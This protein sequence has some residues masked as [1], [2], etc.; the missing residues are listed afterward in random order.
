LIKE[1][2]EKL[3]AA[4]QYIYVDFLGPMCCLVETR[5][6]CGVQEYLAVTCSLDFSIF[7]SLTV[8]P[9]GRSHGFRHAVLCIGTLKF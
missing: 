3:I 9:C 5:L 8:G 4:L 6:D 1:K 7:F 2:R